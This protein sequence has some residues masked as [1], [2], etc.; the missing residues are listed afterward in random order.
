MPHMILLACDTIPVSS[1]PRYIT[2]FFQNGLIFNRHV[3]L[4]WES[5][6]LED[7]IFSDDILCPLLNIL[8]ETYK[9]HVQFV[10]RRGST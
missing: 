7:I 9:Q 4:Q 8:K 5:V 6:I 3:R 1:L 2:Q 10:Q